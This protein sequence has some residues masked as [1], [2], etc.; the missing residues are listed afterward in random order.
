[1]AFDDEQKT[2]TWDFFDYTAV[3]SFVFFACELFFY[4]LNEWTLGRQNVKTTSAFPQLPSVTELNHAWC[5]IQL[6]TNLGWLTSDFAH[7]YLGLL[8][9]LHN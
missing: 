2:A 9:H 7:V 6:S 4:V 1:M 5:G 8:L 3:N